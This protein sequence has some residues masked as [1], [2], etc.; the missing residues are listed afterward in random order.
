MKKKTIIIFLVGNLLLFS[1]CTQEEQLFNTADSKR[2]DIQPISETLTPEISQNITDTLDPTETTIFVPSQD[3][4]RTQT[5]FPTFTSTSLQSPTAT[6]TP[7]EPELTDEMV[8][9]AIRPYAA[10]MGLD[11]NQV[12]QEIKGNPDAIQEIQGIDGVTFKVIVA[13]PGLPEGV[14]EEYADLYRPI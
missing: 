14:S 10:A 8:M 11:P 7:A 1:A 12:L 9:E 6:E 13:S 3:L 2:V 4:K 5:L